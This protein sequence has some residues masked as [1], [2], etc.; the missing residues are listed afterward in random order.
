M[1]IMHLGTCHVINFYL[2]TS[3]P[4]PK[5]ACGMMSTVGLVYGLE[6]YLVVLA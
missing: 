1:E 4:I 3:S 6:I 2:Y 5:N